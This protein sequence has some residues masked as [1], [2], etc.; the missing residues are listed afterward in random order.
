MERNP[1]LD[2]FQTLLG[3]KTHVKSEKSQQKLFFF[4]RAGRH[5]VQV[6]VAMEVVVVECLEVVKCNV[7]TLTKL[8]LVLII[9]QTVL[10]L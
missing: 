5:Q 1:P 4:S 3:P 6:A 7:K 9:P 8:H 10:T 2:H